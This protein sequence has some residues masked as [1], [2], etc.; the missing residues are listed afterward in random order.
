MLIFV[1]EFSKDG[2]VDLGDETTDGHLA[3]QPVILVARCLSIIASFN[4]A[5][6]GLLELVT[7]L[8]MRRFFSWV[9]DVAVAVVLV[10]GQVLVLGSDVS[11]C[12]CTS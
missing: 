6:K 8:L 5:S 4:P 10:V 7:D 2:S 1:L 11:F 3:N 12:V 9:L